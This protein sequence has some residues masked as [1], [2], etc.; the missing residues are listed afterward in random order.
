VIDNVARRKLALDV[1]D[2]NAHLHHKHA[3][4]RSKS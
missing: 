1:V 3:I 2:G 4:D